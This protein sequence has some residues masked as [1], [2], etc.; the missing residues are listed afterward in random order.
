MSGVRVQLALFILAHKTTITDLV[1]SHYR[2]KSS[3]SALFSHL[4][5]SPPEGESLWRGVWGVYEP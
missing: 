2:C 3:L 4:L 5:A 1:G